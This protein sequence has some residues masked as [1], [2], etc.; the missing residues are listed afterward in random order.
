[1]RGTYFRLLY[2]KAEESYPLS[3]PEK[4]E[5]QV[6]TKTIHPLRLSVLRSIEAVF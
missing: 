5:K 1:M 3:S 2:F 6:E 4:A